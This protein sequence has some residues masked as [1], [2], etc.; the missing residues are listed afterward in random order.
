MM[1]HDLVKELFDYRDGQLYWRKKSNKRHGIDKP[2]GT[3]NSTGYC[4]IT[5][6]GKKIHAHRLVWLWHGLELPAMLDHINRDTTDNRI[7]NLRA[8]TYV[9]NSYNSKI[10]ADNK[11][12]VKGVSWCNTYN[13]WIVQIYANKKKLSGR[14]K[15]MDEA[16]A[17]AQTKRKEL[18]GEFACEGE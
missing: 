9:T 2:A 17:F 16:V 5:I 8:A 14:F 11:S 1:Q 12:G 6:N 7:E 13:K 10:K 4:V 3:L 18:H 15:T